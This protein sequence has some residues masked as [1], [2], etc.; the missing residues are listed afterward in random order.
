M[1]IARLIPE[2]GPHTYEYKC[3]CGKNIIYQPGEKPDRLIMCFDC[4][5]KIE[6]GET[7][8]ERDKSV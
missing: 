8:I 5:R 7:K 2:Y 4:I 1:A 3:V 6:K